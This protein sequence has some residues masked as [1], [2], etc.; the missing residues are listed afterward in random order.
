MRQISLAITTFNRFEM[1]MESFAKV[2]EDPRIK[3]IVI[4]D[5]CS[6]DGSYEKL[7]TVAASC[8]KIV[9]HRNPRNLDCYF[10]KAKAVARATSE[11]LVLL[12]SDNAITGKYLDS[13]YSLDRWDP[14]TI[15]CPDFAE[16]HFD[17]SAF[18]GLSINRANVARHMDER[19]FLALLNTCNYFVP[20]G[21]YLQVWNGNV[22]PYTSDSIFHAL[23][24]LRAG[25]RLEIVEGLRYRHRI[26]DG[27]HYK[28]NVHKT[29]NFADWVNQNLKALV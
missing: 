10:N 24:W 29:G 14:H 6:T 23:N 22:N 17:Y 1:V 27:S 21:G 13:L 20:R 8:P 11:W 15:Y 3:E 2:V 26:H 9:L 12:D 16:P 28:L 5:D 25:K 19:N 4:S 18:G 7:Q